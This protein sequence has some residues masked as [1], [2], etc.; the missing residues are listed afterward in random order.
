MTEPVIL[1]TGGNRGIGLEICRQLA[2][3]GARVLMGARDAA[4]GERARASLGPMAERIRVEPL[5]TDDAQSIAACAARLAKDPGR[6]DGLINNAAIY[7]KGD[8]GAPTLPLAVLTRT[9]A[10]NLH[11]PLLLIQA[12]L[13]LLK[14]AG[15]ARV[16]NLS[17]GMGQLSG[18]GPGSAA[19]RLSKTALNGLTATMAS[20]LAS[21][22]IAVNAVCPGW[23]KTDMG[24]AGATREVAQGADT[25][26]W[27]ALDADPA[28]TGR[29]WRDR[30]EIPW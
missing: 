24:G 14:A 20:E 16:V 30:A 10:T 1:V 25:P 23:V 27:L 17:S 8:A 7:D 4:K 28:L 21:A 6:L 18:M 19:Y 26:V 2:T 12:L 9:F 3:R 15:G 22:R 13:P 5:A 29:F 11:G